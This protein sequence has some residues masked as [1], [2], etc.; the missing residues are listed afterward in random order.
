MRFDLL[1]SRGVNRFQVFIF[2]YDMLN[3]LVPLEAAN[4]ALQIKR[5]VQIA[6]NGEDRYFFLCFVIYNRTVQIRNVRIVL[7]VI[8]R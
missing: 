2:K 5:L 3:Q 1:L 7:R 8:N 4:I 6:I